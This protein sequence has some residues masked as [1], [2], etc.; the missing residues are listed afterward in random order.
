M[1]FHQRFLFLHNNQ[2]FGLIDEPKTIY[3]RWPLNRNK[4]LFIITSPNVKIDIEYCIT[5]EVAD[6]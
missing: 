3:Q 1:D 5:S 2:V 6:I 4:G